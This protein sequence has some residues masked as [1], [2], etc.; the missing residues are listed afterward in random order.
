[1]SLFPKLAYV[2]PIPWADLHG[3]ERSRFCEKCGLTVTNL[4]ELS[5][6]ERAA[7]FARAGKERLCGSFYRRMSGEYVTPDAPLTAEER[8]KI[9]Q[10]GVAVLSAGALALAAGCTTTAVQSGQRVLNEGRDPMSRRRRRRMKKRSFCR[11]LERWSV[12]RR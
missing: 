9:K 2:C 7:V 8:S 3:D 10:L 12:R 4:S 11:R 6:A 5:T 1:M